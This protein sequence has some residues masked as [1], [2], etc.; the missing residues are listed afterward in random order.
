MH[1][2]KNYKGQG[3]VRDDGTPMKVGDKV[4]KWPS[5]WM[6]TCTETNSLEDWQVV[7]LTF[8]SG[9]PLPSY[10]RS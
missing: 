1:R 9:L 6:V 7:E 8:I 2:V 5:E 3:T 10:E 4:G